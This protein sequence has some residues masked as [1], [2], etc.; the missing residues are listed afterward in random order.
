MRCRVEATPP[1]LMELQ[2]IGSPLT[3]KVGSTWTRLTVATYIPISALMAWFSTEQFVLDCCA[4]QPHSFRLCTAVAL[5]VSG[6]WGLVCG[7]VCA[8]LSVIVHRCRRIL[9][10]GSVAFLVGSLW[11]ESDTREAAAGDRTT[12]PAPK[13]IASYT[14]E[15]NIAPPG[16][17]LRKVVSNCCLGCRPEALGCNL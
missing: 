17:T 4:A 5:N 14:D 6:S 11:E 13:R 12:F 9:Q 8:T 1:L 10:T 7:L 3:P 2:I 15:I 16:D